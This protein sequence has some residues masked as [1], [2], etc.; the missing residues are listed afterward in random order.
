VK[1]QEGEK[2]ECEVLGEGS[3][4]AHDGVV[5]GDEV[6]FDSGQ[7]QSVRHHGVPVW[8]LNVLQKH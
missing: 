7:D 3:D 4:I 2:V 8:Q 5:L 1:K 6:W